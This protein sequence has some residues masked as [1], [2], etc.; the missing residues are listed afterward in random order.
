MSDDDKQFP[1]QGGY[2]KNTRRKFGASS[3]PWWLAELA[4][5]EYAKPHGASQSL[6]RLAE[7]GGFGRSELIALLSGSDERADEICPE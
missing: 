5:Q 6:E 7:R 3:I 1:I 4:Y 2:Q